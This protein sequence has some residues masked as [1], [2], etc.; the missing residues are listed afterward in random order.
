MIEQHKTNIM[1]MSCRICAVTAPKEDIRNMMQFEA[2]WLGLDQRTGH[3]ICR[4]CASKIRTY[5]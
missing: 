5:R 3:K 4:D 1:S 2:D